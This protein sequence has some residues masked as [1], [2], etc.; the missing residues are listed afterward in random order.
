MFCI[1]WNQ[2]KPQYDL[3]VDLLPIKLYKVNHHVDCFQYF[4]IQS[5]HKEMKKIL[6]T[7]AGSNLTKCHIA[8]SPINHIYSTTYK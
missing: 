2:D 8:D 7:S 3:F 4:S 6:I 1:R 5:A